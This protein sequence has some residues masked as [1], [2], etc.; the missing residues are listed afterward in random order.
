M[1]SE[2]LVSSHL[3]SNFLGVALCFLP[4]DF[5]DVSG[6]N[7]FLQKSDVKLVT[8]VSLNAFCHSISLTSK[9][10]ML[11]CIYVVTSVALNAFCLSKSSKDC[12]FLGYNA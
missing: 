10:I 12:F 6:Y 5:F 2:Y 9:D 7:A 4:Q 8:S 3:T 1:T 11:F